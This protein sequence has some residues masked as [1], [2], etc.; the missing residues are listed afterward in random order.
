MNDSHIDSELPLTETT[1]L[2]LLSLVDG[3]QHGYAILKDIEKV[4]GGRV[5]FSTGTLYGALKRLLDQ[6]WIERIDPQTHADTGRGRKDYQLTEQG[7]HMF[8]SETARL[9]SLATISRLRLK[10][11]TI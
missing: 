4:S 11:N 3:P 2:I 6:G 5:V 9:E 10:R 1:F 7:Q 8:L